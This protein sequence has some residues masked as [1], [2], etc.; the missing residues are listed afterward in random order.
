MKISL[1]LSF[2]TFNFLVSVSGNLKLCSEKVNVT[3]LCKLSLDYRPNK[4]PVRPVII[5]S[6]IDFRK[7][8]DIDPDKKTMT[9]NIYLIMQW[10]NPKL[11]LNVPS[12]N[13]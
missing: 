1:L 9:F 6:T 12:G 5:R 13:V 7:V 11:S 4:P 10:L 2:L 8:L 3:Q